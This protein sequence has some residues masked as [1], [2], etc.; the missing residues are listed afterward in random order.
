MRQTLGFAWK[1]FFDFVIGD[2]KKPLWQRAEQPFTEI[3]ESLKLPTAKK[4]STVQEMV[5]SKSGFS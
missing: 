5:D 1:S 4:L 3:D 2:C